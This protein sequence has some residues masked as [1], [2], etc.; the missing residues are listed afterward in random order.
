MQLNRI[1]ISEEATKRL[2]ILKG[3]TGLTPNILCRFALTY[4]LNDPQLPPIVKESNGQEFNKYTLFGEWEVFYLALVKERCFSDGLDPE[5]DLSIQ[6][7]AHLERGIIGVFSRVK[8]ISDIR[9][10]LPGR[11]GG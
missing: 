10:L 11:V 8:N 2:Q 6:I 1:R 3:R 9:N 7:H 5:S 4:S